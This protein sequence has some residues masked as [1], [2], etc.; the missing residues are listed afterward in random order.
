MSEFEFSHEQWVLKGKVGVSEFVKG[1]SEK[2]GHNS[3][4]DGTWEE[5]A[6]L[7]EKHFDDNEPGIGSVDGDVLLVN[8]P[9]EG[10]H[11]SIVKIDNS[12]KIYLEEVEYVRA[13]GEKPVISNVIKDIP[14]PEA[15]FAKIVVYRADVLAQDNSRSTDCEWEIVSINAQNYEFVPMSPSTML[16]NTN[17]ET[18]GT[19]R[20]Y[21]DEEWSQSY[22]FWNNHASIETTIC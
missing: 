4:Y 12:N 14:K 21:S 18:G 20:V 22:A 8:V 1:F 19:Y 2:I 5:L 10:F 13:P 3:Y 16:R 11:T 17:H 6:E 15:K 7:V 9:P